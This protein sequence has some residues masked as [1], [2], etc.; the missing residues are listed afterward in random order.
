MTRWTPKADHPERNENRRS[1]GRIERLLYYTIEN[2]N[3]VAK[4][5]EIAEVFPSEA[6]ALAQQKLNELNEE[7]ET[8]KGIQLQGTANRV[9]LDVID[10]QIDQLVGQIAEE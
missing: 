9:N 3:R 7:I 4:G 2:G 10:K 1:G 8:L 5:G 6:D